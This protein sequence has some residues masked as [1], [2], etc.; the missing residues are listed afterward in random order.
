[1]RSRT[2]V[3][4]L[5]A[6]LAVGVL[7][8]GGGLPQAVFA[9]PDDMVVDWNQTMLAAFANANVPPPAANRLGGIV[10]AAVFD[11]VNGIERRYAP[12]HVQ[13]AAPDDASPKAAV[14]STAHEALVTLF[15]A[16]KPS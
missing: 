16:Q 13:P 8:M 6:G 10:Q 2:R 3:G 7:F 11:A 14:A 9:A 15:A 4:G 1:M 12:I 5:A